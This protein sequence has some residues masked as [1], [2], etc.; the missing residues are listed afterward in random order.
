[1]SGGIK[2]ST[3][4]IHFAATSYR[5]LLVNESPEMKTNERLAAAKTNGEKLFRFA[6]Q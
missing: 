1:M 6:T 2:S 3:E 5:S 4:L